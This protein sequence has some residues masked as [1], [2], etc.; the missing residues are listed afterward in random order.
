[1]SLLHIGIVLC[2]CPQ[3]DSDG[4]PQV[5]VS[6]AVVPSLPRG[7]AVELH[8]IAVQDRPADRLSHCSLSEVPGGTVECRLVQSSCGRYASVSLSVCFSAAHAAAESVTDALL[9]SYQNA[10]QKTK[11]LSAL[12]ARV[13]YKS[14]DT[15]VTEIATGTAHLHRFKY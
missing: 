1:M 4:A 6:V 11:N 3:E 2:V 5:E 14:H 15:S 13:F 9:S 8:V 10:V 7:A 12:C